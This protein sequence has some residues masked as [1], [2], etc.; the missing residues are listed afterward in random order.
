MSDTEARIT[1]L[2]LLVE[3][4]IVERCAMTDDPLGTAE[5]ARDRLTAVAQADATGRITRSVAN[6]LADTMQRVVEQI[7]GMVG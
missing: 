1:A 5:H 2:E 7:E 3:Q 4:L 6:A